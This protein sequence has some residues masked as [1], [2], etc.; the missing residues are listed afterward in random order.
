[1]TY[2]YYYAGMSQFLE[3]NEPIEWSMPTAIG[4]L[5]KREVIASTEMMPGYI[6]ERHQWCHDHLRNFQLFKEETRSLPTRQLVEVR[7]WHFR[8]PDAEEAIMF[9][10]RWNE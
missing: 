3:V 4:P 6:S 9:K 7:S 10:L 2:F 5:I 1:M 8:I